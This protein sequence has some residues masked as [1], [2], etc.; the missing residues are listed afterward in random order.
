MRTK[1]Y[2]VAALA[3]TML[4]SCA[5]DKFVGDN[6]PN[7][8]QNE[9]T[10]SAINFGGGFKA[11]TRAGGHV[12]ADA[13]SLLNNRFIVGGFKTADNGASYSKVF[14]NYAVTWVENTAGKT[15][16][17]TSDWEYVGVRPLSVATH[18][19]NQTI[20]YWD[21]NDG[22][23]STNAWYDFIAYST[24]RDDDVTSYAASKVA[25][26]EIDHANLETG[27]YTLEA[28]ATQLFDCYVA[29]MN[30]VQK[31]NYGNEVSLQFRSL[32]SK[33]RMALYETVPGYSVKAVKFYTQNVNPANLGIDPAT[34]AATTETAALIG[35]FGNKA[36]YTVYF[37]STHDYKAHVSLT[38]ST[39]YNVQTFGELTANYVGPE[40]NEASGKYLGRSS[41]AV[42]YAGASAPDHYYVKVLPNEKSN[43]GSADYSNVLEL[44]VDY[45]LISTDGSGEEINV[46]GA[47]AYVPAAFTQWLPN[48]AYTYI[49]KISDATNG[50]TSKTSTDP[51]GLFPITFDA[52]VIDSEENTQKTITTVASP[53]ITTYQ[54]G[55]DITKNEYSVANGKIY[56]QVIE[57][58]TLKADLGTN[59]HLYTVAVTGKTYATQPAD[60]NTT[61]NV[62]YTDA[63]L[64]TPATT[65]FNDA[66]TY[67]KASTEVDVIEA[68]NVIESGTTGRNGVTLT[69]TSAPA[70]TT[71]VPG[72]NGEN[73]TVTAG[74][75]AE[76]TPAKGVYA[77]VYDTKTWN[78]I[79]VELTNASHPNFPTGYYTNA[80]CTDA[81]AASGDWDDASSA[82]TYYVREGYIY[83]A[84]TLSS[85]PVAPEAWDSGIWFKDPE[86][87]T[88]VGTFET[89]T[90]YKRYS[91]N[92]KIYAVKV[93]KV[94]D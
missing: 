73:I 28:D 32:A 34:N 89:G 84:R 64:K 94:V 63:D 77:Y 8:V 39:N 17:N 66:T 26:S 33:V 37:P 79:A 90:Y 27:A 83:T 59:G 42:T 9:S 68:L 78:G 74:T 44:A 87:K 62:Y 35:K 45:T 22:G 11:I 25:V 13:A 3:A 58:G 29:D 30:R 46:Y 5:D 86:G 67:Y 57:N 72:E 76:I 51:K 7:V 36:K 49:F 2:F 24:H 20:K 10:E 41:N 18:V 65:A 91:V 53:S 92:G 52:V 71:I 93:I 19:D 69:S 47:T 85:S 43:N 61:N 75:A 70:T 54:K 40:H 50:W 60:Y 48:Y 31:A 6:S 55:H 56:V 1:F 38:S 21:Y 14:D 15:A 23:T 4:A 81:H 16:S 80:D 82:G 88:S 12:G